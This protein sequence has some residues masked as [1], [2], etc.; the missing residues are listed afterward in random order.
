MKTQ[1]PSAF[2]KMLPS[3]LATEISV[4]LR[5]VASTSVVFASN[6]ASVIIMLLSSLTI[7]DV[8][9]KTG[10]SFTAAIFTLP[11]AGVSTVP[12]DTEK[13]NGTSPL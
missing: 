12:S 9:A 2:L 4:T 10:S 7:N 13:L 8:S 5:S 11:C 1:S 6:S 3:P